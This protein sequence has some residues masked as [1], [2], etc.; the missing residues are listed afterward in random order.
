MNLFSYSFETCTKWRKENYKVPVKIWSR[1]LFLSLQYSLLIIRITNFL[2]P[3]LIENFE[4]NSNQI[5][6]DTFNLSVAESPVESNKNRRFLL[7]RQKKR[8]VNF[9]SRSN[10]CFKFSGMYVKVHNLLDF[11]EF[12]L[13]KVVRQKSEVH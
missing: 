4:K 6:R 2:P 12:S 7:K 8:I 13:V 11:Y 5:L 9:W 1:Y 10:F 3:F